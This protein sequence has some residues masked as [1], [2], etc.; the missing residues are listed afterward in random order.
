MNSLLSQVPT[1]PLRAVF[2]IIHLFLISRVYMLIFSPKT[3]FSW[4]QR[5]GVTD[6]LRRESWKEGDS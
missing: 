1:G 6:D 2:E 4:Y 3:S 5:E